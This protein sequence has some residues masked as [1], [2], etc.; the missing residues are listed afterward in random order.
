MVAITI[1][2]HYMHLFETMTSPLCFLC[3]TRR[4]PVPPWA[5]ETPVFPPSP[6]R[7]AVV[8]TPDDVV[9]VR[10]FPPEA[11]GGKHGIKMR[12]IWD[13]GIKYLHPYFMFADIV[14]R[15]DGRIEKRRNRALK[16]SQER[17]QRPYRTRNINRPCPHCFRNKQDY[18][19]ST[20][21][22]QF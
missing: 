6:L 1:Y 17:Q 18:A 15:N 13:H 2:A 11:H 8:R 7:V 19:S 5:H 21:L 16:R 9:F 4:V 10:P 14:W 3:R 12:G 22:V 20:F